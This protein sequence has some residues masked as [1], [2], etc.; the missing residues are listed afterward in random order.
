MSYQAE[1]RRRIIIFWTQR[2]TAIVL[3]VVLLLGGVWWLWQQIFTPST[4]ILE[5]PVQRTVIPLE[6]MPTATVMT[7]LQ[8]SIQPTAV[9]NEA[10]LCPSNCMDLRRHMLDLVNQDRVQNGVDRLGLYAPASQAAQAHAEDMLIRGYFAHES[11]EGSDPGDRLARAQAGPPRAWGE[12]IW[13]YTAGKLNGVPQPIEDWRALVAR[14]QNDWM[15]SS[16]H[17]ANLLNPNFTNLGVGISY[18]PV[19]GEVLM[20]QVFFTPAQ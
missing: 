5:P 4:A 16:G 20:V 10:G 2:I 13:T 11:L 1:R 19:K 3:A 8:P 7:T 6:R 17:R 12:N 15:N 18:D 9:P 14:A